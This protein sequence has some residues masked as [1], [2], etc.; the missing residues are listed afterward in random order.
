MQDLVENVCFV[1]VAGLADD[2]GA[3]Q[4][5]TRDFT[6]VLILFTALVHSKSN[7]IVASNGKKYIHLIG[8]L[9]LLYADCDVVLLPRQLTLILNGEEEW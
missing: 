8:H 4:Y 7:G 9:K 6:N 3:A 5:D 1:V 2:S